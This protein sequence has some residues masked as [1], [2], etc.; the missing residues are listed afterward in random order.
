[1]WFSSYLSDNDNSNFKLASAF[2]DPQDSTD[3]TCQ[4]DIKA[5]DWTDEYNQYQ[6]SGLVN[7]EEEKKSACGGLEPAC[8]GLELVKTRREKNKKSQRKNKG[9]GRGNNRGTDSN[10]GAKQ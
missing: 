10:K 3:K 9:R 6:N 5:L 2:Q 7:E 8:G 1:M 4:I